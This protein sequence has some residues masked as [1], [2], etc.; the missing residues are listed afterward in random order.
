MSSRVRSS[1]DLN[2]ALRFS[3]GPS[4]MLRTVSA[5]EVASLQRSKAAALCM[6][7]EVRRHRNTCIFA[8]QVSLRR[9]RAACP[10]SAPSPMT[11]SN[12]SVSD[13]YAYNN[14]TTESLRVAA[15]CT[16]LV[17]IATSTSTHDHNSNTLDPVTD[18]VTSH[19]QQTTRIWINH[20]H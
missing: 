5:H 9:A 3:L 20:N 14:C 1:G 6:P 15:V 7:Q 8:C 2:F 12:E 17:V 19:K 13:L 18:T 16:I 4:A 10:L 11:S